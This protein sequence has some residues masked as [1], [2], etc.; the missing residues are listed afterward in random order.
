MKKLNPGHSLRM[1]RDIKVVR[2]KVII[3][4]NPREIFQNQLLLDKF[5]NL[6][7]DDG[8]ILGMVNLSFS[9]ELSSR[10]DIKKVLVSNILR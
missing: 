5:L 2:Q 3:V 6:D 8:I 9:I 10:A 1:I 7:S 4:H